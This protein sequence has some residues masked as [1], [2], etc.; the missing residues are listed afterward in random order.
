MAQC[1]I[2]SE[3]DKLLA[4][5]GDKTWNLEPNLSY[6]PTVVFNNSVNINSIDT[7]RSLADFKSLMCSKIEENQPEVCKNKSFMSRIKQLFS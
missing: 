4:S 3:G 2:S 1:A 7:D 5:H 6:V